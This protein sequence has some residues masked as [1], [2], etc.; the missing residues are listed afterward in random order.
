MGLSCLN[1]ALLE[2]MEPVA[3][4]GWKVGRASGLKKTQGESFNQSNNHS[5]LTDSNNCRYFLFLAALLLLSRLPSSLCLLQSAC[6]RNVVIR[7]RAG[8]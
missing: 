8:C 6:V 7:R 1:A 5:K 3:P 2:S 4:T